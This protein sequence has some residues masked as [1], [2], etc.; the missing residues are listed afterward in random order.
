V[1]VGLNN[2]LSAVDQVRTRHVQVP[3]HAACPLHDHE[4]P[5]SLLPSMYFAQRDGDNFYYV[6]VV[7]KR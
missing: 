6:P 1:Y 5:V 7:G 4:L 3:V 2:N